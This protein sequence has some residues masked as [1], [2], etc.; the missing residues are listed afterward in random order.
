MTS[1][2]GTALHFQK[3]VS[4]ASIHNGVMEV[5]RRALP[6]EF[7]NR[8][9]DIVHFNPLGRESMHA[10]VEIQLRRVSRIAEDRGVH[11]RVT[12]DA[13]E[14]LAKEGFDDK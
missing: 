11:L 12:D 7:I 13:K 1:N 14:W 5:V 8:I 4:S 6:P 3:G 10:V 2:L 9:D